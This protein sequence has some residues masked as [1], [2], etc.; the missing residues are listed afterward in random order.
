MD[1]P[2]CT[3]M[4][5]ASIQEAIDGL[6]LC[7]QRLRRLI[8]DVKNAPVENS[9]EEVTPARHVLSLADF[10]SSGAD[11]IRNISNSVDAMIGE[12]RS[13]LF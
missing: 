5:H 8:D 11:D 10:L 2:E 1:A 13:A 3:V 4:M 7:Q 12:L 9:C 6:L